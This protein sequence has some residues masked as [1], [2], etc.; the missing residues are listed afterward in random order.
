MNK[1]SKNNV[2]NKND[3][4]SNKS[5]EENNQWDFNERNWKVSLQWLQW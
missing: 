2:D 1:A 5:T 4:K 3:K